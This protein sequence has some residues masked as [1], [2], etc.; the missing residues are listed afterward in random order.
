MGTRTQSL[1]VR[2]SILNF[3]C[4]SATAPRTLPVASMLAI[5]YVRTLSCI[6]NHSRIWSTFSGGNPISSRETILPSSSRIR[7]CPGG[8]PPAGV[9]LSWPRSTVAMVTAKS[10]RT[11]NHHRAARHGIACTGFMSPIMHGEV[12][13]YG[14]AKSLICLTPSFYSE[15]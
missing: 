5:S 4:S 14:I 13:E 6:V 15:Y 9:T 7:I 2:I 3:T 12:M 8:N 10:T 11:G 1:S